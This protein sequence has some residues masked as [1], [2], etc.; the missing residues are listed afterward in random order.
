MLR[1]LCNVFISSVDILVDSLTAAGDAQF[2]VAFR[3]PVPECV[4]DEVV[5]IS[6]CLLLIRPVVKLRDPRFDL[7]QKLHRY[8]LE[9]LSD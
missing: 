9:P 7:L 8:L 4:A 3:K 1:I 2:V 5:D 6:L